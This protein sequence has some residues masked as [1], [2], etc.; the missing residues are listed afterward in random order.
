MSESPVLDR[1]FGTL[2]QVFEPFRAKGAL[3]EE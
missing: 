3:R 2:P 1:I